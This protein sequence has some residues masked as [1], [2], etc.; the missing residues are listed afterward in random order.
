MEPLTAVIIS[1]VAFVL[2]FIITIANF[3]RIGKNMFSF[4][5]SFGDT[6]KS[7][8]SGFAT[9]AI[10]G[11]LATLAFIALLGSSIWLLVTSFQ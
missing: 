8:G 4:D 7:F 3:A 5:Q 6:F 1:G 9:H 10:F 11:G 2:F